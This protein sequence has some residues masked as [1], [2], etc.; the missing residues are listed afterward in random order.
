MET[1]KNY[2]SS[3]SRRV[4]YTIIIV[5]IGIGIGWYYAN[6]VDYD[7]SSTVRDE[8]QSAKSTVNTVQDQVSKSID[9]VQRSRDTAQSISD[10]NRE[11]Q[12]EG[13]R[14][15]EGI[16]KLNDSIQSAKES[17]NSMGSSISAVEQFQSEKSELIDSATRANNNASDTAGRIREELTSCESELSQ[18]TDTNGEIGDLLQQLREACQTN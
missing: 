13:R 1:I 6:N 18:L 17:I 9:S 15:A 16:A 7:D 12:E 11:L 4:V 3:F 10:S 5:L 8:I 2:F 14:T